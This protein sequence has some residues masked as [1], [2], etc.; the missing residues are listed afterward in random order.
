MPGVPDQACSL[1]AVYWIYPPMLLQ[2][3]YGQSN[4]THAVSSNTLVT[5]VVDNRG[6]VVGRID[7][8]A[9]TLISIVST[10]Q[11]KYSRAILVS[12]GSL[13]RA[14]VIRAG[15]AVAAAL[16]IKVGTAVV[17]VVPL[18]LLVIAAKSIK[19]L[20]GDSADD[21]VLHLG[22]G[23]QEEASN[24][25]DGPGCES[26]LTLGQVVSTGLDDSGVQH[27]EGLRVRLLKLSDPILVTDLDPLA[28]R[29]ERG[30]SR[31]NRKGESESVDELH[32]DEYQKV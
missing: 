12:G 8:R 30:E 27:L 10:P 16:G 23:N 18:D 7:P 24:A 28:S 11:R 20:V 9:A 1:V 13:A 32:S 3:A 5:L 25:A 14:A 2:F 19:G 15:L 22:K 26:T 4:Y 21:L 6:V 29:R 31:D 17:A